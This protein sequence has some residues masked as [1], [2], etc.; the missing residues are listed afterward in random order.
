MVDMY[1]YIHG[2][3]ESDSTYFGRRVIPP[4]GQNR[5]RVIVACSEL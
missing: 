1:S 2:T 4:N 3:K 5:A